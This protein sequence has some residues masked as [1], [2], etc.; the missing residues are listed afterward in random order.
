MKIQTITREAFSQSAKENHLLHPWFRLFTARRSFL[1]GSSG[2]VLSASGIALMGAREAHATGD[3]AA[4]DAGILNTML[5]SEYQAMA[6]YQVGADSGLLQK[7]VLDLA[8]EFQGQ[9][10]A[11]AD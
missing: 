3:A 7:P 6:A 1:M 10:N 8:I 4:N 11:H 2:A 5:G 9:H